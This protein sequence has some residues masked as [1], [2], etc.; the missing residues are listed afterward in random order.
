MRDFKK[1]GCEVLV[2]EDPYIMSPALT[3]LRFAAE[4][5]RRTGQPFFLGVGFQKSGLTLPKPAAA[6]AT[7]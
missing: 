2:S 1:K 6:V 7:E 3:K 4:N 5:R